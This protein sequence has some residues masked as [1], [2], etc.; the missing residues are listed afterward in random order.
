MVAMFMRLIIRR[1]KAY[2][3]P[4]FAQEKIFRE[5]NPAAW[6]GLLAEKTVIPGGHV[7]I[8]SCCALIHGTSPAAIPDAAA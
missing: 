5:N 6:S 2:M 1:I 8:P 4:N 7:I 3:W